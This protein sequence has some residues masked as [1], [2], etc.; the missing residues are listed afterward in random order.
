MV[1]A[2]SAKEQLSSPYF[3]KTIDIFE[4]VFSN[5]IFYLKTQFQTM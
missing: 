1:L 4:N 5:D 2:N 3:L